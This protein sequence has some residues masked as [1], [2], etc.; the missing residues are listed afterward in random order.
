MT[1]AR[2]IRTLLRVAAS[3]AL[4]CGSG[5]GALD[6]PRDVVA[7][8]GI[9]VD[10]VDVSWSA[11]AGAAGYRVWRDGVMISQIAGTSYDDH[12]AAPGSLAAPAAISASEGTYL[13]HVALEWTAAIAGPGATHSYHVTA[14]DAGGESGLSESDSGYRAASAITGYELS[15]D[16]GTFFDVGT[17]TAFN[18]DSAPAGAIETG[19]PTASDGSYAT[20]VALTIENAGVAGAER[21]YAVRATSDLGPGEATQPTSGYRGHSALSIRWQRSS[22]DADADYE[23]LDG[24]TSVT[25][26]D[27]DVPPG[28][29]RYY[30]AVVSAVGLEPV[31]SPADSGFRA[32]PT[33]DV[34]RDDMWIPN[35]NVEAIT[36]YNGTLYM[37]GGFSYVGPA[38]GGFAA[39]D[40]MTGNVDLTRA[41]VQGTVRAIVSDG[42]G[43]WYIGGDFRVTDSNGVDHWRLARI[44]PSGEPDP[45][46]KAN[47]NSSVYALALSGGTLYAGGFFT[48]IEGVERMH[49][50]ALDAATGAIDSWNPG[51][52][53][54][55]WSLLVYG[56]RLYV[57]GSF[58]SIGGQSRSYLA[59]LNTGTGTATAWNPGCDAE[60]RALALAGGLIYVG[61][62]FNELAGMPHRALAALDPATGQFKDWNLDVD[63]NGYVQSLAGSGSTVFVGGT[64]TSVASQGRLGLAALVASTGVLTD[65]NPNVSGL[66]YGIAV[67][68]GKVYVAG[69]LGSF[70][71]T[72]QGVAAVDESTGVLTTTWVS[73]DWPLALAASGGT[74]YAGG[75]FDSIGGVLRNGLAAIDTTTGVV[76]DWKQDY[77]GTVYDLAAYGENVYAI[78]NFTS[79]GGQS[80]NG[81]VALDATTGAVTPWDAASNDSVLSIRIDDGTIYVGGNFTTIGGQTR[82][83]IASL[84]P[85]TGQASSWDPNASAYV[86]RIDSVADVVYVA[87][88]FTAIGGKSRHYL[89]ALGKTSGLATSWDPNPDR[90]VGG[91]AA[92]EST[93]YL[94]G[95]FTN[96][97]TQPR[98]GLAAI[99]ANSGLATGWQPDVSYVAVAIAVSG[100]TVYLGGSFVFINGVNIPRLAALDATSG[101]PRT[102][103]PAPHDTVTALTVSGSSVYAAGNFEHVGGRIRRGI[104]A[105][106]P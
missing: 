62:D 105:F 20:H 78:G 98:D 69:L 22:A 44:M 59:A 21:S 13:D 49:I 76:T 11:V 29:L 77:P 96:V 82:N 25:Q 74:I 7:S 9:S 61:G 2:I 30:R 28:E 38:T 31:V 104:A 32:A 63:V 79:V 14:F 58:A 50:A 6:A 54:Q 34:A 73:G 42:T 41:R 93:V 1:G 83:H 84:D 47:P 65:W 51:A 35:G 5:S 45:A 33:S 90:W 67:S 85:I 24:A 68:A 66:P 86:S 36:R 53:H 52:D 55:V 43:G 95:V 106:E 4:G 80:R 72:Y 75:S 81:I 40:A 87:G 60:V 100:D 97:G 3:L 70:P 57:G 12:D 102:W 16:G 56:T 15:I 99:D 89:A 23:D 10:Q 91:L 17:S 8:D 27:A 94:R 101:V 48:S 64:F 46:W 19:D 26:D 39:I 18:D 37:A 88:N 92:T 71:N 103:S